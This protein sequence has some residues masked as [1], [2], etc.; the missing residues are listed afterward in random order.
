M[1]NR[2]PLK[3]TE[4]PTEC[5]ALGENLFKPMTPPYCKCKAATISDNELLYCD[6]CKKMVVRCQWGIKSPSHNYC[7]WLYQDDVN[8][9]H[10]DSEIAALLG[11]TVQRVG[12]IAKTVLVFLRN[13]KFLS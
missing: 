9:P 1:D 12:Q 5:C 2:C 6:N 8:V 3:L 11:I 4:F 10:N 7:F 13:I